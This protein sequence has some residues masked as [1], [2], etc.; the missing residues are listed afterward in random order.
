MVLCSAVESSVIIVHL[1]ISFNLELMFTFRE[2]LSVFTKYIKHR[3]KLN[4][5]ENLLMD[6]LH[7]DPHKAPQNHV[8]CWFLGNLS[9]NSN[10][11]RNPVPPT[12]FSHS[13]ATRPGKAIPQWT[14]KSSH[15]S[16]HHHRGISTSKMQFVLC[17]T[18]D[19]TKVSNWLHPGK[20]VPRR[21]AH[22]EYFGSPFAVHHIQHSDGHLRR[23]NPQMIKVT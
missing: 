6:I 10:N 11:S 16:I 14:T 2:Q 3:N 21:T 4:R 13:T 8:K 1:N 7:C 15:N 18:S 22:C 9:C 17:S 12:K 19:C 20:T 5:K 23:L